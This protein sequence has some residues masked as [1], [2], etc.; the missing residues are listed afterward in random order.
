[1][2]KLI[3]RLINKGLDELLEGEGGCE[4]EDVS[5]IADNI[6]QITTENSEVFELI[7][8]KKVGV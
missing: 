5:L 3:Y 1:M 2:D 6:I 8:N 4:I 7:I